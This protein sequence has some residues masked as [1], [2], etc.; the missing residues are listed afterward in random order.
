M[1][2]CDVAGAPNDIPG[3]RA[4]HGSGSHTGRGVALVVGEISSVG[5]DE[6]SWP[7]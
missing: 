2:A 7:N 3:E 5:V 1:D 4:P 6:S